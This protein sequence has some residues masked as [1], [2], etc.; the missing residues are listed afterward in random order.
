MSRLAVLVVHGMGQQQKDFAVPMVRRVND[1][2]AEAGFDPA[3]IEWHS[4]WWAPVLQ[5]EQDDLWRRMS[6]E[7]VDY[8][9]LRQF[10]VHSLGDAVAYRPVRS[11]DLAEGQIDTYDAIH[12]RVRAEM[13]VLRERTRVGKDDDDPE[14]PLVVLAHSLG[15]H[16]M[17]NY[18]WDRQKSGSS[19]GNDFEDMKTLSGIVT[20][21][22]NIP[23]FTLA[24]DTVQPIDF[25]VPVQDYFPQGTSEH[26]IKSA[27]KWWNFYDPDDILGWP[28][29]P[30]SP[31]YRKAVH[32]DVAIDVGGLFT[33]WN[34]ASHVHYWEDRHFTRPVAEA[35]GKLL[36]LL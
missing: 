32:R 24:Y 14:V 9:K 18:I 19:L 13:K 33:S 7:D 10:V 34:P 21:G 23:M 5:D 29:K 27:T 26:A 35:L 4:V 22:C 6:T 17:S 25:P 1:H 12:A 3:A 11:S 2:V 20:F 8:R 31:G 15:S 28:L 30:L 16:V 36:R